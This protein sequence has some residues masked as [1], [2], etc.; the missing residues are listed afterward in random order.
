MYYFIITPNI[1]ILI[2]KIYNTT[3][4]K[5]RNHNTTKLSLCNEAINIQPG[6]A[7]KD[8]RTTL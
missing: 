7:K 2:E 1:Y 3:L 4:I 6:N 8:F 5:F